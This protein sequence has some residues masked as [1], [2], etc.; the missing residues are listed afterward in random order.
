[1]TNPVVLYGTQSNG[2]T[3]PVQVD[4]TGRL[5]A[6]GLPGEPGQPGPPGPE[7]PPGNDIELPPDPYEGALL[8][9]LNG[10]LAWVG[11]PPIII[12]DYVFGPIST[13][14]PDQGIMEVQSAVPSDILNGVYLEQCTSQGRPFVEGWNFDETWSD[15]MSGSIAPATPATR[16]FDGDLTT[17]VDSDGYFDGPIW[18]PDLQN[19]LKLEIYCKVNGNGNTIEVESEYGKETINATDSNSAFQWMTVILPGNGKTLKSIKFVRG[20]NTVDITTSAIKVNNQLLADRAHRLQFRVNSVLGTT[21]VGSFIGLGE[22]SVGQYLKAEEQRV[23]PWVLYG[24]DP[25]SRIDHLR[26]P[27]D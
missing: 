14:Q 13:V 7:G 2:E 4:A 27:R 11:A 10:G 19:V 1:M 16:L 21:L 8:G 25:T 18:S 17:Y 20:G 15:D 5:V 9:W 6:E 22:F 12:P 23:A 3:L 24:N 26:Q